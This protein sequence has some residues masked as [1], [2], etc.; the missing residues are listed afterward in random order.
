MNSVVSG[1]E[2]KGTAR[3]FDSVG[4][5]I[6]RVVVA[7]RLKS[8]T[9]HRIL[10]ERGGLIAVECFDVKGS[11]IYRK[12]FR[13]D[14]TVALRVYRKGTAVDRDRTRRGCIALIGLGLYSVVA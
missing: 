8:L 3:D 13:S 1:V 7:C 6:G 2:I 9:A 10:V 12:L 5:V 11:V 14:N 4:R